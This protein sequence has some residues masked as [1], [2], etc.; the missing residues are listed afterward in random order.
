M[1][2]KATIG[3]S[4]LWG[5]LSGFPLIAFF[6]LSERLLGLP[7]APF[8]LF[9]WMARVLP[10]PLVTFGIDS[11]VTII[12]LLPL[13]ATSDLAKLAEQLMALI[14]FIVMGAVLGGAV[15]LAR[16]RSSLSGPGLGAA[17]A[18]LPL[19]LLIVAEFQLGF[20]GSPG[21]VIGGMTVLFLAWGAALGY[22][23]ERLQAADGEETAVSPPDDAEIGDA[24][25]RALLLRL[26]GSSLGLALGAW[27]VGRLASGPGEAADTGAG[28]PLA[29]TTPEPSG[30]SPVSGTPNVTAT[31]TPNL[32]DR[33][34]PAPG[35]RPEVTPTEDFYRIDINTRPVVIEGAE[36][37]LEVEGLFQKARN[38][39][40]EDL[41]AYPAVTQPITLSCISNRIAGDLISTGYWTGARLRDVLADL[42]LEPEAGALFLEAEDGFFETVTAADMMDERTL[43]VYG[44]NG[45]T[46]PT[47]HGYP[48]RIYIPNRYGMKQPKWITRM[49]AIEAWRPGYWVERGWSREAR[50]HV[51]SVI[52]SVAEDATENGRIPIGG[53]AWAGDRG[54][55]KVEVRVDDG[56]W[57]E[58]QLRKPPLST[59]TW[60][61]WRYDWPQEE[62]SHTFTV[63][64]TDGTGTLQT[65]EESDVRPDGATGY[66][67]VTRSI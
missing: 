64:A 17:A 61:Q 3:W 57:Q 48:L 32:A 43:L 23:V 66:H 52:D 15:A 51:I 26:A 45:E 67:S 28:Q 58:A 42:Q 31:P 1:R 20:S 37:E 2:R 47:E 13:G 6:Y 65:E 29:Q 9:D 35:T 30:T 11:I 33:I 39:T 18:L 4:A 53:V 60:V 5:A 63:R 55:Q 10:G 8:D 34:E 46:L 14:I 49:E 40:I 21:V 50:P 19:A 7:F 38:L 16:Q 36:W 24:D 22:G 56:E 27:G 12:R 25:R 62:G 54:I 44:M 59:L 41:M